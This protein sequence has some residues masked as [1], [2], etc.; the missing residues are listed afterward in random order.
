MSHVSR[1]ELESQR[2]YRL[3]VYDRV[4]AT[5]CVVMLVSAGLF[6][7]VGYFNQRR[8]DIDLRKRELQLAIYKEKKEV[9]YP[10]CE[11]A[12]AIISCRSPADA[13]SHIQDYLTLYYGKARLL[14]AGDD[15]LDKVSK[16][17]I[18][19]KGQLMAW[20]DEPE[21][22]APPEKLV[23]LSEKLTSACAQSLDPARV[24]AP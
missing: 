21:P 22:T 1:E 20:I 13:K 3:K 16:S 15:S 8:A 17:K 24:F 2:D 12:A 11:S 5:I 19:F 9:L 4:L 6:G 14:F 23:A 10:L 18:D 7:L